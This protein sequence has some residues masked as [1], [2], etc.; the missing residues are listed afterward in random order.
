MGKVETL[1]KIEVE[2]I[3]FQ[4]GGTRIAL[5]GIG[6]IKDER[7]NLAFENK[8]I[9]FLR[10]EGDWFNILIIHQTKERGTAIGMN[11]RA[12][13]QEKVLPKFFNLVIWGHEHECI[14]T[15]KQC[16]YTGSNILYTGS[17]VVTSL[18]DSEAKPKHCFV[19]NIKKLDFSIEAIPLKTAR[20]FVYDQIELGHTGIANDEVSIENYIGDYI[21]SVLTQASMEREELAARSGV[22]LC[23]GNL[24]PLL[25]LKVEYS[26]YSVINLRRLTKSLEGR[27]ANWQRD[28]IKFYKRPVRT[29]S[30]S[31]KE[32][33]FSEANVKEIE[34]PTE[35]QLDLLIERKLQERCGDSVIDTK[36]FMEVVERA[37]KRNDAGHTIEGTWK[38]IFTEINKFGKKIICE[39]VKELEP[40]KGMTLEGTYDSIVKNLLNIDMEELQKEIKEDL[41]SRNKDEK[42]DS[43]NFAEE[44][45]IAPMSDII[46]NGEFGGKLKVGKQALSKTYKLRRKAYLTDKGNDKR[47]KKDEDGGLNSLK[48]MGE[49]KKRILPLFEFAKK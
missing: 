1:D 41:L 25:R 26:G 9:K 37:S 36:K 33:M 30:E 43:A 12:Y 48:E 8:Q 45:K 3:L 42:D 22:D 13:I 17:T 29:V 5:Y 46:A 24:A 23:S 11:K 47:F 16:A 20:P 44:S 7:F 4:K 31:R 15:V 2:P 40:F 38:K 35:K 10:P 6:Y 27:I 19:L 34:D 21:D 32:V 14:P 28:F 39:K 18:I 49:G